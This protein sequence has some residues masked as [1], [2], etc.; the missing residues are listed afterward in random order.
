[1]ASYTGEEES[2]VDICLEYASNS[3]TSSADE[4]VGRRTLLPVQL[5]ILPSLQV[6]AVAFHEHHVPAPSRDDSCKAGPVR[7][8]SSLGDLQLL[9]L[10]TRPGPPYSRS[11]RSGALE[12]DSC[13]DG[14]DGRAS[15][16]TQS[17]VTRCC[18]IEVDAINCSDVTLQVNCAPCIVLTAAPL[19][20]VSVRMVCASCCC[21]NMPVN[22]EVHTHLIAM[23]NRRILVRF[24]NL[25][26]L[27]CVVGV[28]GPSSDA[29]ILQQRLG[30]YT[31]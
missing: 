9:T 23:P 10:S 26:A 21:Q 31:K 12:G 16:Y 15:A 3:D 2:H 19:S 11:R 14:L 18:V 22:M 29:R 7:R 20:G 30:G 25:C 24:I 6:V 8:S 28:A 13:S 17:G 27:M 5:Q 1:V 4:A